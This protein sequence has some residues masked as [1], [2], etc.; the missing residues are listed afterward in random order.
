MLYRRISLIMLSL[1][2]IGLV[3]CGT[4]TGQST[5]KDI[6]AR[7]N[8]IYTASQVSSIITAAEAKKIALEDAGLVSSE[9]IFIHTNYEIDDG[10][11][12]YDVEFYKGLIEYDYEID[13]QTGKIISKDTDAEGDEIAEIITDEAQQPVSQPPASNDPSTTQQPVQEPIQPQETPEQQEEP[14]IED[15][16]LERAKSI[17]LGRVG[18]A[19]AANIV[20]AKQEYDDGVLEYEIEII[21]NNTEYDFEIRA[22]DGFI[23][24]MESESIYD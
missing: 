8:Q 22:T 13:A 15:I 1:S 3:G 18:G 20:K 21:Y 12:L 9:V 2:L 5:R 17:A 16:G 11:Q 10:R 24:S 4:A 7:E 19:T 23:I 6:Q 14:V